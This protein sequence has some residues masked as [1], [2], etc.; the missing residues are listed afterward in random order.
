MSKVKTG[1][2][3]SIPFVKIYIPDTSTTYQAGKSKFLF[4]KGSFSVDSWELQ[5]LLLK[6]RQMK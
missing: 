4:L 3:K 2:F 6:K 1:R 5:I